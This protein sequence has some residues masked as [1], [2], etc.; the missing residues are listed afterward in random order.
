MVNKKVTI[1]AKPRQILKF[2]VHSVS[3]NV[4]NNKYAC[5]AKTA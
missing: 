3:I 4:V 5:V 1:G 2:V